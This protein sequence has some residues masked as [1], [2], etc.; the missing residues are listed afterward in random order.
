MAYTQVLRP[1]CHGWLHSR[2]WNGTVRKKKWQLHPS[3]V[4]SSGHVIFVLC[5]IPFPGFDVYKHLTDPRALEPRTDPNRSSLLL[6][7]IV[8]TPSSKVH[9]PPLLR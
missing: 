1:E 6:L 4:K 3:K 5:F 7:L 9:F 2:I 8:S